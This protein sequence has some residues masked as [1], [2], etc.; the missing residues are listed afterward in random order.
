MTRNVKK[1][2]PSK[3][4]LEVE[5]DPVPQ[6]NEPG[7]LAQLWAHAVEPASWPWKPVSWIPFAV[8]SV[9]FAVLMYLLGTDLMG[10]NS[11]LMRFLHRVNLV[12]HEFGHPAFSYFGRT[13]GIP[14]GNAGAIVDLPG[15]DGGL[16]AAA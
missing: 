16:L 1:Y 12:F 15:G 13:L 5:G 14:G 2:R 6:D 7:K 4:Y 9:C 8:T 10:H 11:V 3:Q